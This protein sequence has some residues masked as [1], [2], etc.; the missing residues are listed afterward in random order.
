MRLPL[1][2]MEQFYAVMWWGFWI[3]VVSGAILLMADATTKLMN[4]DFYL[5]LVFIA[6]A[7]TALMKLRARVF[8]DPNVRQDGF[9]PVRGAVLSAVLIVS[10]V[11]VIA[12][13][14]F[15]AYLGPVSGA[16]NL[17]NTF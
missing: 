8:R 7:M 4:W 16:P 13:G 17:S 11:V 1:W 12:A 14:R 2:P 5:K 15:M 3:N 9:V 10:W 6:L